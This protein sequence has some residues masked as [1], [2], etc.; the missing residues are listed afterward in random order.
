M[1]WVFFSPQNKEEIW[2]KK[3][4]ENFFFF[5]EENVSKES[6]F[7]LIEKRD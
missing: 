3:K 2:K 1:V 5:R 4:S 7:F 6:D